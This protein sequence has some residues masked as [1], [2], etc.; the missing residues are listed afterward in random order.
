MDDENGAESAQLLRELYKR[1]AYG[2][3]YYIFPSDDPF[4]SVGIRQ[5]DFYDMLIRR[6]FAAGFSD[7]NIK[8]M[9]LDATCVYIDRNS[10]YVELEAIFA[11]AL[12]TSNSKYK[13]IDIIKE[14]VEKYEAKIDPKPKYSHDKYEIIR[15]IEN[16]C[17]TMLLISILLCEPDEA[18]KYYWEHDREKNSE[19]TLYKMLNIISKFGGEDLWINVYEDALEQH[20]EPRDSLK[21]RYAAKKASK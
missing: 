12:P 21:E 13:A 5:P 17:D 16:L 11:K 20:I 15:N 6:T 19:I 4:Q 9:L 18:V 10:L 14:Y 3:G 2:C 7:E 8:N 1:L